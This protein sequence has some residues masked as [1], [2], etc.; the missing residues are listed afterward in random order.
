MGEGEVGHVTHMERRGERCIQGFGG[1]TWS[2]EPTGRSGVC[3]G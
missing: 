2:S 3:V 1:E